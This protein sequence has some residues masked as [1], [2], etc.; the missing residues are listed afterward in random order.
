MKQNMS[1]ADRIIRLVIV[2]IFAYLYFS[3]TAEGTVGLILLIAAI[4]FLFTSTTGFCPI[5]RIFGLSTKK[6]ASKQ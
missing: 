2:A 5:Y 3:G 6:E 4:I 1:G